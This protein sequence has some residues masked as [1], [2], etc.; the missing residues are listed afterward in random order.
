MDAAHAQPLPSSEWC[1]Q[2]EPRCWRCAYL[3]VYFGTLAGNGGVLPEL[4]LLAH[5]NGHVFRVSPPQPHI[6]MPH[7]SPSMQFTQTAC[8]V[9]GS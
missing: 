7:P 2:R 8:G 4:P 5:A 1:L 3:F 6:A 9:E